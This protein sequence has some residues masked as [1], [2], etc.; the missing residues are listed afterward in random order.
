MK[1][2][3]HYYL[4]HSCDQQQSSSSS[5]I[6]KNNNNFYPIDETCFFISLQELRCLSWSITYSAHAHFFPFFQIWRNL[7]Y[8]FIYITFTFHFNQ[9]STYSTEQNQAMLLFGVSLHFSEFLRIPLHF[10]AFQLNFSE[11]YILF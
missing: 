10:F 8:I 9:S 7:A 2:H 11:S 6:I 5:S 3:W 1:D 4:D